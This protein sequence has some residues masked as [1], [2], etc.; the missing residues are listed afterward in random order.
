MAYPNA[1]I[2]ELGEWGIRQVAY[3]ETE[4]FSVTRA[5]LD[6]YPAMLRVLLE[7]EE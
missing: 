7:E 1:V 4:H 5:F 2:L 6:R 3:E